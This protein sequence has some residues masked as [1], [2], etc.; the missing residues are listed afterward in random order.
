MECGNRSQPTP[1]I[2][3]GVP[4]PPELRVLLFP[5]FLFLYLL[6]LCENLL[7]LLAVAREPWL[8]KPMY[9]F[10]CHLSFLDMTVSSVVVPKV[11]PGFLPGSR[12][13]SF[14]GCVARSSTS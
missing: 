11:V 6:T 8:Y 14:Q 13:I 1:F 9:W 12:I 4:Y 3:V 5:F 10:L 2:L 7:V